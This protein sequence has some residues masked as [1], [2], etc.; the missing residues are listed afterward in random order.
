MHSILE[1]IEKKNNKARRLIENIQ[2]INTEYNMKN[3]H[4]AYEYL[5]DISKIIREYKESGKSEKNR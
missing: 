2:N 5:F 1:E 3:L 4:K